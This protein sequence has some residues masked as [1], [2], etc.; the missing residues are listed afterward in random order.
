MHERD[1][2]RGKKAGKIVDNEG[3]KKGRV[4]QKK[5]KSKNGRTRE[6]SDFGKV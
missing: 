4:D 6:R 1:Y 3:K 2:Y 5:K